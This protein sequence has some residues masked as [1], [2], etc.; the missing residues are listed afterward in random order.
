MSI[1]SEVGAGLGGIMPWL[2]LGGVGIYVI[3]GIGA[4]SEHN[5]DKAGKDIAGTLQSAE[6]GI[7]GMEKG[8]VN[9]F[10]GMEKSISGEIG[11]LESDITGSLS[12]V[13]GAIQGGVNEVGQASASA[14]AGIEGAGASA[15][16]GIEGAGK[17][18]IHDAITIPKKIVSGAEGLPSKTWNWLT[19]NSGTTVGNGNTG[20]YNPPPQSIVNP[21]PV[22]P[23]PIP[24]ESGY[25]GFNP[26]GPEQGLG[27]PS[28]GG[29]DN[30]GNPVDYYT[31]GI[32]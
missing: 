32:A 24:P 1:G 6:H 16:A 3:H 21:A 28:A 13:E 17:K 8:F 10:A 29:Y 15:I 19:G 12:D 27:R 14:I 9:A 5:I 4:F 25:R 31:G 22:S 2:V 7:F 23:N 30:T 11:G 20:T 18:V 26:Y